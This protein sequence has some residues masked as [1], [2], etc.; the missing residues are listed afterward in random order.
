MPHEF[1]EAKYNGLLT[2]KEYDFLYLVLTSSSR[3]MITRKSLR[4]DYK[5]KVAVLRDLE[6][7][8]IDED[9][10]YITWVKPFH[11]GKPQK[12]Y[13]VM[14]MSY[15]NTKYVKASK[16][17]PYNDYSHLGGMV[18]KNDEGYLSTP[19]KG[20]KSTPIEEQSKKKNL[21]SYAEQDPKAKV[22]EGGLVDTLRKKAGKS[23]KKETDHS[24]KKQREL[25]TLQKQIV[26]FRP[27]DHSDVFREKISKASA[28]VPTSI[29]EDIKKAC[30]GN[31]EACD[32]YQYR[33]IIKFF[34]KMYNLHKKEFTKRYMDTLFR[35]AKN[36][37]SPTVPIKMVIEL[38]YHVEI[39]KMIT[40]GAG[41]PSASI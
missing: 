9:I 38:D 12:V 28:S 19:C 17:I 11:G 7:K 1:F 18:C 30:A 21:A 20:S 33:D 35:E 26:K 41:T 14:P 15:W 4:E 40:E 31:F 22:P 8:F 6:D 34:Q 13:N 25:R 39:V 3:F 29:H 2:T 36:Q 37:G 16:R 24:D 23:T 32:E 10:I 5:F 27:E